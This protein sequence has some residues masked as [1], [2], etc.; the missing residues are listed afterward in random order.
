MPKTHLLRSKPPWRE[1]LDY[2]ICGRVAEKCAQIT[3]PADLDPVVKAAIRRVGMWRPGAT[4]A[5]LCSVCCDRL[6]YS[7]TWAADPVAVVAIDT[8]LYA[9]RTKAA[10]CAELRALEALV[11]E[12][13]DR[14]R[15]LLEGE[16]VMLSLA[17]H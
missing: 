13:P 5:G 6:R 12:Y 17:G 14:F 11:A 3:D 2:S 4:P 15:E 10:L 7:A 9:G 1:G 16:S 8:D